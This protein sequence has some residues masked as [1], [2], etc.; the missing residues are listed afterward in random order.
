MACTGLNLI[1]SS[2]IAFSRGPKLRESCI[3]ERL[4]WNMYISYIL[5]FDPRVYWQY[6]RLSIYYWVTRTADSRKI[7]KELFGEYECSLSYHIYV[8]LLLSFLFISLF[9]IIFVC[10]R[11]NISFNSQRKFNFPV[12][13]STKWFNFKKKSRLT[14]FRFIFCYKIIE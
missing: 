13:T 2:N 8:I 4:L 14:K 1:F 7:E 12:Q 5:W 9:N 10:L 6:D 11:R 3:I